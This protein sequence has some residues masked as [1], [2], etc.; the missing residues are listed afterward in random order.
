MGQRAGIGGNRNRDGNCGGHIDEAL[1]TAS[2]KVSGGFP[3]RFTIELHTRAQV[4][5]L[6]TRDPGQQQGFGATKN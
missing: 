6:A 5:W 1:R 2:L 4:V 3:R